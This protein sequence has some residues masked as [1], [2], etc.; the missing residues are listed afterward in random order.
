MPR[1][2]L[3]LCL[4]LLLPAGAVA[5]TIDPDAAQTL[6]Q[7]LQ[8]WF[9]DLLGPNL[10]APAQR[11]RVTAEDDHF[12]VVLPF[13]DATGDN[14]VSADVRPLDGGRW[15]VDAL[16]LPCCVPLHPATCRSPA[17]RPAGRCRPS[18]RSASAPRRR[19]RCSIRRSPGRRG[20]TSISAISGW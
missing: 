18:S 1:I 14:E 6:Q 20:S 16:H 10:G 3:A 15:S 13:T 12:R 2:A 17:A 5:Q 4:A 19:T 11:L 7:T 9:A 8:S